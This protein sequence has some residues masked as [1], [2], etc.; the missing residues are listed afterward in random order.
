MAMRTFIKWSGSKRSQAEAIVAY[1]PDD[2]AVYY[3]PFL[4]SG[5]ILGQLKPK[6]AVGA[7]INQP[8]IELWKKIQKNPSSVAEDYRSNWESLQKKGH[9]F[10]YQIRNRF[11]QE[12]SPL[13]FLFL[14]RTCVNGLIRYNK[15]GEFN[16]SLH[17][18]RKGMH[19]DQLE[20]IIFAWSEMIRPHTFL[21]TSYEIT[22]AKA[23][24][25]DFIYL[26]P[27]YV[28][29]G[30]RYFGS[31]DFE[32]FIGYL[33]SLNKKDIRY[34]LSY[35]GTRGEKSYLV[36]LPK[37]LYKR[38]IMLHSGN[39]TFGKVQNDKVEKVYESLYLN[40]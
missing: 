29:T 10:F 5:A 26:D 13:D 38:H 3:E 21:H 34:A 16:N 2:I 20:K 36:K 8:L 27:P 28:N 33:E 12:Q 7:D 37:K 19:P 22:T 9:T 32:K 25:R 11:N 18:T 15:S 23:K 24:K 31:I 17:H 4:G 39:S 1:L 14:T 40:Y 6:K 30:T 35:D